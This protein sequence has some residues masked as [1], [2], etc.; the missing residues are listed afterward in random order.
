MALSSACWPSSR[1][2]SSRS[3]VLR[4]NSAAGDIVSVPDSA[5]V[6][7]AVGELIELLAKRQHKAALVFVEEMFE[8][9]GF[10]ALLVAAIWFL[11]N[12]YRR[13]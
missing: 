7:L 1:R 5:G 11:R 3:G 6:L 13:A 2:R 10:T 4:P 12:T 8:N 9:W